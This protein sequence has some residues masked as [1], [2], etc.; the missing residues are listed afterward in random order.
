VRRETNL[1]QVVAALRPAGCLS[2]RLDRGQQKSNQGRYN[3]DHDQELNQRKAFS[4]A[5]HASSF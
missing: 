4:R 5:T 2:R 3:R 1:L